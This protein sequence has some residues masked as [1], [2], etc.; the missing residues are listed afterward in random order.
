M[1][2]EDRHVEHA[3]PAKINLTLYVTGRR[4]D[5]FH[6][7]HSVVARTRFGDHLR[8]EWSPDG[9]ADQDR[10]QLEEGCL[11]VGDNSVAQAIRLFRESSGFSG[12]AL[13]ARLWK[14]IPAGA[15]LG[16][17]SSDAV[18]TLKALQ[19]LFGE[20]AYGVDWAR[21]ATDIGSDCRLF[22]EEGPVVMTGRG[23]RVEPLP[24][25][26]ATR[27]EGIPVILFKPDFP[28][29]TPEAYRRLAAGRYYT[30]AEAVQP[31]MDAWLSGEDPL[32]APHNDF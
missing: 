29:S 22:L 7:L 20:L 2:Q 6:E 8:L 24:P 13:T 27:L 19:D 11:P 28:I 9:S 12:G 10:V 26:A 25:P 21:L 16:G 1:P 23:D 4:P 32:P 30:A 18:A 31:A 17:G 3:C 15:G 5:G 14:R